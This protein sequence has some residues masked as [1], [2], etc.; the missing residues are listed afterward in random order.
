MPPK[1]RPF[2]GKLIVDEDG[3]GVLYLDGMR[4]DVGVGTNAFLR[5]EGHFKPLVQEL[6]NKCKPNRNA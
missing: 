1:E 5:I 4:Y 3:H 2:H 6:A